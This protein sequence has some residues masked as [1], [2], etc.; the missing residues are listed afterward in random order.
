MLF[1]W[2]PKMSVAATQAFLALY[3]EATEAFLTL[4]ISRLD[5]SILKNAVHTLVSSY[6]PI[7]LQTLVKNEIVPAVATVPAV[8]AVPEEPEMRTAT[9][10]NIRRLMKERRIDYEA[11]WMELRCKELEDGD[12]ICCTEECS[13]RSSAEDDLV[14]AARRGKEKRN[15]RRAAAGR[16]VSEDEGSESEN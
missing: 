9:E 1:F 5:D 15:A 11:A 3:R 2:Y 4:V 14:E 13:D 6:C 10:K 16:P 8:P 12:S 7:M